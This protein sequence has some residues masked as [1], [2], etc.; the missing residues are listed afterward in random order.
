MVV[1]VDKIQMGNSVSIKVTNRTQE[2]WSIMPNKCKNQIPSQQT[3]IIKLIKGQKYLLE[4][5][6]G[7]ID[8]QWIKISDPKGYVQV[9]NGKASIN[10]QLKNVK[11]TIPRPDEIVITPNDYIEPPVPSTRQWI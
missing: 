3:T 6:S 1:R 2:D 8:R 9:V 7:Q 11:I 5:T 10:N 4:N